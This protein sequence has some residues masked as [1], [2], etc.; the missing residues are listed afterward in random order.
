MLG[1][2]LM[3]SAADLASCIVEQ[4]LTLSRA[5]LA[6]EIARLLV[7]IVVDTMV[8]MRG[9]TFDRQRR[10]VKLRLVGPLAQAIGEVG[11]SSAEVAVSAHRAIAVIA[12]DGHLGA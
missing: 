10:L 7:V 1:L 8:P 11:G 9:R 6:E 5:H 2:K 3:R 4:R 12:V